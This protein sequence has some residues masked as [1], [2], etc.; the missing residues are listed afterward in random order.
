MVDNI[1]SEHISRLLEN[2]QQ[3]AEQLQNIKQGESDDQSFQKLVNQLISE[4]DEAQ[5]E[6]DNSIEKL[7]S[8]EENVSIQDV[9]V[10]MKEAETAFS[11]MTEIRD[12]L[13]TAYKKTI[14]M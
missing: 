8:G 12:K 1:S 14:Q 6:A 3:T 5:Q 7:A 9:V 13:I 10:K 4:V 11:L 2:S